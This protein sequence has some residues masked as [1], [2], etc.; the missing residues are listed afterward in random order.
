MECN[1]RVLTL[2][3]PPPFPLRKDM[4][5]ANIALMRSFATESLSAGLN[6][7]QPQS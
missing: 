6:P 2:F 3:P 4:K 1:S 7:D 5:D